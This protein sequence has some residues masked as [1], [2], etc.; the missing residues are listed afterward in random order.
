[1]TAASGVV[2]GVDGSTTAAGAL[3]AAVEEAARRGVGVTAMLAYAAPGSWAEGDGDADVLEP[4][5]MA[6]AVLE[7]AQRYVAEATLH[8]SEALRGVP[9]EVRVRAGS[10]APVL[11][12]AA[13]GAELL[14]VGHRGRGMVGRA[15]LGSTG[16]R[17]LAL[18]PCPVLVVRPRAAG[19][20][21]PV[22]V[23]IDRSENSAAALRYALA[24]ALRRR[25]DVVAVT[26]AAPPPSTV[27]FRPLPATTLTA[28]RESLRPRVE[29][30]VG[31]VVGEYGRRHPVP[32]IE[33]VVR[34]EDP[35]LAVVD[36][37]EQIAAPVVV[38]GRTG[39]GA[40]ARW[41]L[42]SVAHGAVLRAP[43]PVVVVPGD[44]TPGH[45]DE[46]EGY[47]DD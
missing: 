45:P 32:S 26:G 40:F 9:L 30:F 3:V 39:H 6:A 33:V 7:Q 35:T 13:R 5:R 14:V 44:A 21:G 36:V 2:V 29:Q 34:A 37:A 19:P 16:V 41:L 23:G 20:D 28:V 46:T 25:V 31:G 11:A 12:D 22:V 15:V 10:P 24:D 17:L 42:G 4:D 1:M 38:V 27:G 47:G 18:A 43:C 8:L